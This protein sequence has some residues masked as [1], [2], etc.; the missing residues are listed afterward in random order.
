MLRFIHISIF[1]LSLILSP[2]TLCGQNKIRVQGSVTSLET[3]EPIANV[4]IID[5]SNSVVLCES[6]DYGR[7]SALVDIDAMLTLFH[8]NYN[9]VEISL[10]GRKELNVLMSE[11]AVAIEEVTVVGIRSKNKMS[12]EKT[13]LDIIGEYFHLDTKFY[14]P[15]K[16]F[17]TDDRFILQPTIYN[18]TRE[19]RSILRPVVI[20]GKNYRKIQHRYRLFDEYA[21][22]LAAYVLDDETIMDDQQYYSYRDSQKVDTKFRDDNYRADCYLAI[23]SYHPPFKYIDTVT[24]AKGTRNAL[25]FFEY[26][27]PPMRMD[28]S[29][30]DEHSSDDLTAVVMN[31]KTH[32]PNPEMSLYKSYGVANIS[33]IINSAKVDE[34]NAEN[35]RYFKKIESELNDVSLNPDA[36]LRS[37]TVVGYASPDGSYDKNFVLATKRTRSLLEI[38]KGNIDPQRLKYV[39]L[40]DSSVVSRWSDIVPI[41]ATE[42]KELAD[43]VATIIEKNNDDY[44]STGWQLRRSIPE[45]R[46]E[47][48]A[49]YLPRM[50]RVNT[51][52]T[53][54]SIV[55]S[56]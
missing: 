20:D 7:F 51:L 23:G 11:K 54:T 33:Y 8:Y 14:I 34:S 50:R 56:L 38:V 46:S 35:I 16:I 39:E 25:R 44:V 43:R 13:D 6:D 45:Y 27:L 12:V 5:S 1:V 3:G 47:I 52:S 22:P 18:V 24:I 49:K 31:D 29:F 42:N 4:R 28:Q 10:Q 19:T 9:Q 17:K 21:D 55:S 48:V 41:I 37:I 36:S 15:S 53:I 26:S 32:T 40:R 2:Y 30:I